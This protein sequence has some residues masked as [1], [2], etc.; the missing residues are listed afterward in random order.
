MW[1]GEPLEVAS[2]VHWLTSDSDP[3]EITWSR[4]HILRVVHP[5]DSYAVDVC[6]DESWTFRG[7]DIK[8]QAPLQPTPLGY[9][10]TE[11]FLGIWVDPDGAWRWKNEG[12]FAEAAILGAF[13]DEEPAKARSFGERVIEARPWPTG[14]ED[15]RPPADWGP[16]SVSADWRDLPVH[17][18][19]GRAHR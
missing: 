7:W 11:W 18:P 3:V 1:M 16:V 5:D 2:Y 15:W 10:T 4:S 6:W 8:L 12:D 19:V 17:A 14:S 9:D 13:T